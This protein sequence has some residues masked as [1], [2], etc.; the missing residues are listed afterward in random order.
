[1]LAYEHVFTPPPLWKHQISQWHKKVVLVLNQIDLRTPAEVAEVVDYVRANAR[2]GCGARVCS[3]RA[4]VC[5]C[6]CLCRP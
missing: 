2:S 6:V 3:P 1:M 5:V 4:R